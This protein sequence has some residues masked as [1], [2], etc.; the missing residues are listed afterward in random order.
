MLAN[1]LPHIEWLHSQQN[2]MSGLLQSWCDIPSGSDDLDGLLRMEE[3][4]KSAFTV[5]EGKMETVVLPARSTLDDKGQ[6]MPLATGKALRITKH[7]DAPYRVLLVGHMD[8]V[9]GRSSSFRKAKFL[10][11]NRLHG[12][13]AADM[14]GGLVVLL[15]ALESLERS[16]WANKLGWEVIITP[17]EETGSCSSKQLL[18]ESAARHQIGMVFEPTLPTGLLVSSRKGS[19]TFAVTAHGKAAHVGR[20]FQLGRNAI[21]ALARFVAFADSLNGTLG[22]TT[23]NIG[24]FEGG[25]AANIVPDFASCHINVRSSVTAHLDAVKSQ[26]N[27]A[28]ANVGVDTRLEWHEL[29][30]RPAKPFDAAT[31][32]LF[33]LIKSCGQALSQE[34]SWQPSGGVCDGNIL[35]ASGLPTIDTLGVIG[36]NLHTDE[37]WMLL[38]SLPQKAALSGLFLIAIASESLKFQSPLGK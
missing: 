16:P 11:G 6:I 22:D 26:L 23:I 27:A 29:V 15:K 37:E 34:I 28:L 21:T 24:Q 38:D 5:L 2:E 25:T 36:G 31:E 14:K 3:A 10:S 32:K 19:E 30:C 1:L 13:G 9:F 33:G 35:A 18:Q 4:L 12:P 17:D 8:T 20:D 7:P